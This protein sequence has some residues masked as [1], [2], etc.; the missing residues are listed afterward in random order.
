MMFARPAWG[1]L[2]RKCPLPSFFKKWTWRAANFQG[3]FAAVSGSAAASPPPGLDCGCTT[4][5]TAASPPPGLEGDGPKRVTAVS[6][7]ERTGGNGP[8]GTAASPKEGSDG[9]RPTKE[10]AGPPGPLCDPPP[11]AGMLKTLLTASLFSS[12]VACEDH[13]TW[14][15]ILEAIFFSTRGP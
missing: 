5:E 9:N 12:F 1:Q 13:S 2:H 10:T 15:C 14:E 6:L 7:P 8:N 11:L 3:H 4:R